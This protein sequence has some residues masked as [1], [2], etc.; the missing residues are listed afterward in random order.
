MNKMLEGLAAWVFNTYVG[1][2]LENLNTDQLSIGLLRGAVELENLPLK[3]D[4]LKKFDLPLEVKAGFVGKIGLHIPL[5]KLRSEP[6]VITIDKLYLVAGPLEN[7]EYDDKKEDATEQ[8]A[9]QAQLSALDKQW[10]DAH[11]VTVEQDEG[12]GA[13]WWSV[14]TSLTTNIMENLQLRISDVH[15]RYENSDIYPGHTLACGITIS[16]LS[17]QSTDENWEPK[18]VT[19]DAANMMLKLVELQDFSIYWDTNA[20]LIGDLSMPELTTHMQRPISTDHA[21]Q[22]AAQHEYILQPVSAQAKLRRNCSVLPL[23][24]RVTPRITC[25]LVMDRMQLNIGEPQ[26]RSM[27]AWMKEYDRFERSRQYRRWRPVVNVKDSAAT[28]WKFCMTSVLHTITNRNRRCTKNFMLQ[29]ARTNVQYVH[30]YANQLSGKQTDTS[31][32]K[33]IEDVEAELTFQELKILRELAMSKAAP[34]VSDR[35][36]SNQP[37]KSPAGDSRGVLK[38]WFPGW[39]GWYSA[40]EPE[41]SAQAT[42][43]TCCAAVEMPNDSSP[44]SATGSPPVKHPKLEIEERFMDVIADTAENNTL[45]KRDSVFARLNFL[46]KTGTC[47]LSDGSNTIFELEFSEVQM[48][49]ESRPRYNSSEIH[50]TLGALY[51]RDMY[52]PN[53]NF[54]TLISPNK[55]NLTQRE[56]SRK[57]SQDLK[58]PVKEVNL[59]AHTLKLP[60]GDVANDMAA[61]FE[62]TFEKNPL[63]STAD[64]RLVM[65]TTSL[66]TIY[67]PGAIKRIRQ[68]FRTR[69]STRQSALKL[70]EAARVRYEQLKMQTKAELQHT[71]EQLLEGEQLV[72]TKRWDAHLNISAPQI[73]VPESFQDPNTTVVTLLLTTSPILVSKLAQQYV[74]EMSELQVLV[75]RAKDNWKHAQKRGTGTTHVLDRFSISLQVERRILYTLEPQWPAVTLTG[76]LPKLVVHV[77]EQKIEA[78]RKCIQLFGH[79]DSTNSVPMPTSLGDQQ[80]PLVAGTSRSLGV[81][82]EVSEL[83]KDHFLYQS[84]ISLQK[85]PEHSDG[86]EKQLP[87]ETRLLLANF[88]VMDLS[89]DIQSRSRSI[90]ELQVSGVKANY[91]RRPYDSSVALTVHG[92]LLIDAIQT[93]GHDFELLVASHKFISVDSQSG[94]ICDS[95]PTS[96]SEIATSRGSAS[97]GPANVPKSDSM[98]AGVSRAASQ[99]PTFPASYTPRLPL[100]EFVPDSDALIYLEFEQVSP[101]SPSNAHPNEQLQ[102]ATLTFNNLNVTANQE[103]IVELLGFIQQVFPREEISKKLSDPAPTSE[104]DRSFLVASGQQQ[105]NQIEYLTR[106]EVTANF[107]LLS[108]LLPRAVTQDNATVGR[109]VAIATLSGARIQ[110]TISSSE[111]QV[112]GSLGGVQLMD[113]TP[114]GSMHKEVFTVGHDPNVQRACEVPRPAHG[115]ELF[116]STFLDVGNSALQDEGFLHSYM[117][118]NMYRTAHES[119]L[120]TLEL[121]D[122]TKAF[123]FKIVQ[124]RADSTDNATVLSSTVDESRAATQSGDVVELTLRV[125]SMKY[126]HSPRLLQELSSC[127]GEFRHY[128]DNVATTIRHTATDIAIGIVHKK[129]ELLTQSLY[130][131]TPSRRRH[132]SEEPDIFGNTFASESCDETDFD[133]RLDVV[134]QTPVIVLPRQQSSAEALVMH[135]GK[136]MI[137]NVAQDNAE[138]VDIQSIRPDRIYVEVRDMNLYSKTV[139]ADVVMAKQEDTKGMPILHDTTVELTIDRIPKKD[140]NRASHSFPG[141]FHADE[142]SHTTAVN[143]D[144]QH[145]VEVTSKVV[146]PL[147]VVLSKQQYEQVLETLDNM[148]YNPANVAPPGDNVDLSDIE[149]DAVLEPSTSALK[150]DREKRKRSSIDPASSNG[151]DTAQFSP[152]YAQ[153]QVPDFSV[154]L[155]GNVGD[156]EQAL[157]TISFQDF[158][159]NM[160]SSEQSVTMLQVTLRALLME[161]MLQPKDSDHKY[162]MVSNVDEE[163]PDPEP[164]VQPSFV[165]ISCPTSTQWPTLPDMPNSLPSVLLEPTNYFSHAHRKQVQ[166]R[167]ISQCKD[168]HPYTPPPSPTQSNPV[169]SGARLKKE[170]E[171]EAD[172]LVQISVM[173]VDKTHPS[174]AKKY[175]STNRFFDINFNSLDTTINLQ[176][177]V[178]LLDFLGMGAKVATAGSPVDTGIKRSPSKMSSCGDVKC[179]TVIN[180]EVELVV[181]SFTVVLNKVDYELARLN[182]S[183]LAAH[184]S[185]RDGNSTMLGKLGS[186]SVTDLTPHGDLYRERFKTVGDNAL[187]FDVFKYG[188]PDPGLL[189]EHDMRVKLRMSSVRILHTQRFQQE[190]L[191]FCQHF[192]QLQDVLGRMRAASAGQTVSDQPTTSVRIL[193]DIQAGSP[194]ILIPHSARSTDILVA[195]LGTLTVSNT[196]LKV[197]APGTIA[198][199]KVSADAPSGSGACQTAQD[200][201]F[202][203]STESQQSC[204][205]DVVASA[206]GYSFC[207]EANSA[208]TPSLASY[209]GADARADTGADTGADAGSFSSTDAASRY[210]VMLAGSGTVVDIADSMTQSI[211]GSLDVDERQAEPLT[212]DANLATFDLIDFSEAFPRATPP[213]SGFSDSSYWMLPQQPPRLSG[214]S[215]LLSSLSFPARKPPE[216]EARKQGGVNAATRAKSGKSHDTHGLHCS[217]QEHVCLLDVLQVELTDMDLYS[218]VRMS[219]HEAGKRQAGDLSFSTHVVRRKGGPLLERTC[220]LRLQVERN[221]DADISHAAP[222]MK[223]V[224]QLS[225][226]CCTIDLA[227]Y[228]LLRGV[229]DHNLGEP[230]EDFEHQLNTLK[231]QEPQIQTVL[232]G[233]VWTKTSLHMELVNVT[234]AL[235]MQ[236]TEP[237]ELPRAALAQL[238][239]I[240]SKLSYES[241]SDNSKDIDLVSTEILV[242]DTRYRDAPA[243][244]RPNVFTNVLQPTRIAAATGAGVQTLQVEVHYRDTLDFTRLTVL[245]NNMR[246][247]G[248]FD[249]LLAIQEFISTSA[250]NPY[251]SADQSQIIA[252]PNKYVPCD[253]H[254]HTQIPMSVS[255]SSCLQVVDD[256]LR[257][258]VNARTSVPYAF[259]EPT[260][261]P[262]ITCS[263]S[264]GTSASYSLSSVGE[265]SKDLCYEN[266]LYIAVTSTFQEDPG[267]CCTDTDRVF[268]NKCRVNRKQIPGDFL[269]ILRECQQMLGYYQQILGSC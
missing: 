3:R 30:T 94:S 103:T 150:L 83:M 99:S 66:D 86:E 48:E 187:H 116:H 77:N 109:K 263:V 74:L 208:S 148:T 186:I 237:S 85:A 246:L 68:F 172:A 223:V 136:I 73:I 16:A 175:N 143:C 264:G 166:R 107:H 158:E 89:L 39:G 135:L 218:A 174:F 212:L 53:S 199:L 164:A 120:S 236:H 231:I 2:Y 216:N 76:S 62:L 245:L 204:D 100:L 40:A 87:E 192:T 126:T 215:Q 146:S 35:V 161:D 181:K 220:A 41:E 14:G 26:Y 55:W 31:G 214:S 247:M 108:I 138:M 93:S 144:D 260:L 145:V 22:G 36:P 227:Q 84:T 147:M 25:D 133:V 60:Q 32:Q 188:E 193:L 226:V 21:Q 163:L 240:K 71:W 11:N 63:N 110:A 47:Q 92:L 97:S 20:S 170:E 140:V 12:Y 255:V 268:V 137:T 42:E 261:P 118:A 38:R 72:R 233:E 91:M 239:F 267:A 251:A 250:D 79:V 225:S 258:W 114:E 184:I 217:V 58:T 82:R 18:F 105:H 132:L 6:W 10:R 165:S 232:S 244:K 141:G 139:S 248:I 173:L 78:L 197:G 106:T 235:V 128:M 96:P 259:D 134:L 37:H 15:I 69:S 28:W 265:A 121:N 115:R 194:V 211:Y 198:G 104:P 177:W 125:A 98:S 5:T 8:A 7:D 200:D 195:D 202:A 154:E 241:Y 44:R 43:E 123:T 228:K 182:M 50:I 171:E 45:L 234:V 153:L 149:E 152:V 249:W 80:S 46:L 191:A 13:S 189:R 1:E 169:L 266:F 224:G 203:S 206:L 113:L 23:R 155:W 4:A 242:S 213:T 221:L 27:I 75:G 51:L 157:V 167:S 185:L 90:A 52:T 257:S 17:A 24:S 256:R 269:Q 33:L 222:G 209:T 122:P 207:S 162:I 180:S 190:T 19:R 59:P 210:N 54:G 159:V 230:L 168:P 130:L 61:L 196:F 151:L 70:T 81:Q 64:Y 65:K 160:Q 142:S 238:D 183:S 49:F 205:I 229:L 95:V 112:Q 117:P 253:P 131:D 262:F 178:M 119:L 57:S 127:V 129:P 102:V 101:R 29:R 9:K 176:T 254:A 179:Q 243:N 156:G 67:N 34:P 124:P 219:R 201:P 88:S 252:I 56:V 111:L